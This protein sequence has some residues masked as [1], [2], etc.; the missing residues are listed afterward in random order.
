MWVFKVN[1]KGSHHASRLVTTMHTLKYRMIFYSLIIGLLSGLVLVAYRVLGEFLFDQVH[2][3]IP[4]VHRHWIYLP[5]FFLGLALMSLFVSYCVKKEANISGS[6]IPQVEGSITHRLKVRWLRVLFY[7]FVGG[8]VT[9]ASGL[10]VGREGP[11]IQM[12]AAIGQ[13]VS[14]GIH[15]M[16]HEQKYLITSG[17]SAGLAAAFN[18]PLS[19]VMFALEEAHKNFSPVVL[20]SAMVAALTADLTAKSI[21]GISPALRFSDLPIMPI[22]HYWSLL[23]LGVLAGLS[24]WLFNRGI[25]RAKALY[26]QGRWALP[27]K[28]LIPFLLAGVLGL[29]A[30][31]LL[32][33]G[34]H[35]ILQLTELKMGLLMI[36]LFLLGKFLFTFAS[37]G[38]GVPGGIFFPLLAIGAIWGNLLGHLCIHYLGLDEQFMINFVILAM[39]GHFAAIVKAP[40]T[41]IILIY[42]MTGSF[43]QLLPLA[44][45]VFVA[46]T[47][48]DLLGVEPIYDLLLEDLLAHRKQELTTGEKE[49]GHKILLELAVSTGS[50]V[51][52]KQVREVHWPEHCLVV[53]IHRGNKEV[54]PKG[55]SRLLAGDLLMVMV[56]ESESAL[57]LE[58]LS[59]LTAEG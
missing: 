59:D 28:I 18:A 44:V 53:A 8:I 22:K 5:L 4:M 19:G 1:N 52:G 26:R 56:D 9:L 12:G 50:Q 42:E 20:A 2:H 11:S 13:G 58:Q 32:G 54:L 46:L 38:S 49:R 14:E 36:L 48:S 3:L 30:P 35:L 47:T 34:H 51:E 33:G 40:I 24:S 16:E 45:V 55:K 15:S 37:F 29:I 39:A 23:I 31:L 17:A 10:S 27:Y 57:L 25:M 21:L 6:G 41:G 43:E 7:K